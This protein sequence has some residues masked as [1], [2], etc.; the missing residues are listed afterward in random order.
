MKNHEFI[1]KNI[2]AKVYVTPNGDLM[3]N[4]SLRRIISHKDEYIPLTIIKLTK[5]GMAYLM[6]AWGHFYSVPPRN[7][8]EM[9]QPIVSNSIINI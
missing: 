9:P 3:F 1:E 7:V 6:D 5:S 8:R 4:G 2:G